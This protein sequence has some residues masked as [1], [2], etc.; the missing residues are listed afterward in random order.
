M[1]NNN[2]TTFSESEVDILCQAAL[3]HLFE[4]SSN[5]TAENKQSIRGSWPDSSEP[6]VRGR[7]ERDCRR[8]QHALTILN[9][10]YDKNSVIILPDKNVKNCIPNRPVAKITVNPVAKE[11]AHAGYVNAPEYV[12]FNAHAAFNEIHYSMR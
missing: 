5:P 9:I 10:A 2:K 4:N 12:S 7:N 1:I 8:L 3:A 6:S 11:I